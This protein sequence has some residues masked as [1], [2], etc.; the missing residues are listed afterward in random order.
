MSGDVVALRCAIA[1]HFLQ[2]WRLSLLLLLH[3]LLLHLLL[4]HMLL[5]HL[6]MRSRLRLHYLVVV[7]D[8]T[9][10]TGPFL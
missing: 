2:S 10:A 8:L 1:D 6:L 4:L 7:D 9:A 5:L 3:M